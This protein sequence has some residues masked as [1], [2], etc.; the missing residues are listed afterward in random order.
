[1]PE[2]DVGTLVFEWYVWKSAIGYFERDS[3]LISNSEVRFPRGYQHIFNYMGCYAQ[4]LAEYFSRQLRRRDVR[5]LGEKTDRNEHF[6]LWKHRG[7]TR[8]LRIHEN[9]LRYVVQLKM[10]EMV[11]NNFGNENTKDTSML[12]PIQKATRT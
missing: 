2:D 9:K 1:M 5:I 8:M 6:V 12:K 4:R 3:K 11:I 10:N 7:E